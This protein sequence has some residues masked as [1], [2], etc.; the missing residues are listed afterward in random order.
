GTGIFKANAEDTLDFLN[1][2]SNRDLR[3]LLDKNPAKAKILER[4]KKLGWE[5]ETLPAVR[6]FQNGETFY[7]GAEIPQTLEHAN[8]LI[9]DREKRL[10]WFTALRDLVFPKSAVGKL[11]PRTPP[12]TAFPVECSWLDQLQSFYE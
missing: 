8:N 5:R 7:I 2:F 11:K 3:Q 9:R 6:V 12:T 1:V 4:L 10:E